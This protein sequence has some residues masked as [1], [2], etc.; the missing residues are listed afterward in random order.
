LPDPLAFILV[1][2]ASQGKN[3]ESHTIKGILWHL[4]SVNHEDL[5]AFSQAF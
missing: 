5:C 1:D 4:M 2:L 3:G